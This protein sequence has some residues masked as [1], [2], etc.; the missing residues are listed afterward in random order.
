M[1]QLVLKGPKNYTHIHGIVFKVC[2]NVTTKVYEKLRN[3]NELI[4]LC[5]KKKIKLLLYTVHSK[6]NYQYASCLLGQFYWYL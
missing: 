5:N 1:D 6:L 3:C 4:A 2:S